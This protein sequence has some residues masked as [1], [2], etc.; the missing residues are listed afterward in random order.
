MDQKNQKQN[1]SGEIDLLIRTYLA[2]EEKM[3]KDFVTNYEENDE[4]SH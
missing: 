4:A 1:V 2:S 3:I